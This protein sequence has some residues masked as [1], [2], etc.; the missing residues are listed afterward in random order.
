MEEDVLLHTAGLDYPGVHYRGR[1]H[2]SD[3]A[4]EAR[5]HRH[6]CIQ[7]HAGT[8]TINLPWVFPLDIIPRKSAG[9]LIYLRDDKRHQAETLTVLTRQSVLLRCVLLARI[10]HAWFI[11][12]FISYTTRMAYLQINCSH[13]QSPWLISRYHIRISHSV[14]AWRKGKIYP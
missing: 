10:P 5:L 6:F 8:T 13:S 3:G 12:I 1:G 4:V 7:A 9:G 14:Y 2:E 11:I